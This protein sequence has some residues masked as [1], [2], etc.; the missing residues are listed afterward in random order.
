MDKHHGYAGALEPFR[1]GARH[2]KRERRL[3]PRR[4]QLSQSQ[5]FIVGL[6][7]TTRPESTSERVLAK[8]L[9]AA[10]RLGARTHLFRGA[11]LAKLPIYDPT[12]SEDSEELKQLLEV[13]RQA[14]GIL[15]ATPGYHGSV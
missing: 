5:P 11:F 15:I 8:A 4:K 10:E 3:A 14:D 2:G 1:R 7:G 9:Q 12:V 13:I 6:G